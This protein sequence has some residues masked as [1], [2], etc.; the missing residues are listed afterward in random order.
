MCIRDRPTPCG[1]GRRR[2]WAGQRERGRWWYAATDS[3]ALAGDSQKGAGRVRGNE[4]PP[5]GAEERLGG[6]G[7]AANDVEVQGSTG[8]Q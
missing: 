4:R 7:G 5:G 2:A 3:R 1:G 6:V 8:P